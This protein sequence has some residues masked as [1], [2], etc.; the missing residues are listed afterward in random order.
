MNRMSLA[1]V[2]A[3]ILCACVSSHAAGYKAGDADPVK[4]WGSRDYEAAKT[5]GIPLCVYIFDPAN[6]NNSRAKLFE[7]PDLLANADV[8]SKLKGFLTLKIK[9]DGSDV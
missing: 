9:T 6:N 2:V 8:K 4:S 7:G 1:A 3:A 5:A